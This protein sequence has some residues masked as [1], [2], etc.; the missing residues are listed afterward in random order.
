MTDLEIEVLKPI[1]R[2]KMDPE[3]FGITK[4]DAMWQDLAEEYAICEDPLSN[5]GILIYAKY[6]G[7]WKANPWSVRF[8]VRYLLE[9][10]GVKITKKRLEQ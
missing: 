10:T 8:L 3:M 1:Y 5:A 4:Q 9:Q 7:S 6:N 2:V